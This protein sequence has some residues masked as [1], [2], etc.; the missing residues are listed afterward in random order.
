MLWIDTERTFR[1]ERLRDIL[2]E[3]DYVPV[4]PQKKKTDPKEPV[5]EMDIIKF[6]DRITVAKAYNSAH[7]IVILEEVQK[8]LELEADKKEGDP[9]IVL[10]IIDSLTT[11]FRSEYVG[12]GLLQP[13]QGK[14]G[15]YM[16]KLIKLAEAYNIAVV[17]T[18]QVISSPDQFSAPVIAV[19]GNIVGH[20]ATYRIWLR[21]SGTQNIIAKMDDSPMHPRSEIVFMNTKAG[22][23]DLEKK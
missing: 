13:R 5:N 20:N 23:V 14:I 12:R 19:G 21:R 11:H 17:I 15:Q 4:K 8:M 18:N 16:K 9:R 1:P 6:L 22:P 3:R 10:I 7:Q 2:L